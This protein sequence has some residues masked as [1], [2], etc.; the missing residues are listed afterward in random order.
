[1]YYGGDY[2]PEQWP[3]QTWLE[4][5]RLMREANVNLVSLGVFSWA[6]IQP[7]EG[8][9]EFDWLDRV[10]NLLGENDIGVNLATATASP[11]H[12]A[13]RRY[14][15]ILPVSADGVRLQQGSRQ[16][17]SPTS[18]DYRRLA[19]ELASTV[20][21]RYVNHPAVK[22]W[23]V[24]NE[25]A[26]HVHY[27]YSEHAESAF[28]A[29]LQQKYGDLDKLNHAWGTAFWSQI[30]TSWDQVQPPR[31]SP[32]SQNP[33]ATLDF[34]RFT[35]DAILE[36]YTMERDIIRAAGA[37]QPITTNFMGTFPPLDYWRWAEEVD[38]VA[39]DNYADP[40]DPESFREAALARA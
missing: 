21:E 28:R 22:M 16:H 20:A 19:A 30:H 24:N 11:P 25:Y 39:D 9:F 8:R 12:W 5:A 15:G 7:D 6:K 23:H 37:M 40:R 31:R 32:Y 33:A 4:D 35:S 13:V 38:V 10:V 26:C 27:D 18:P 17:Y 14:P 1:M 36:L 3:E 2:N 29:W 34:R